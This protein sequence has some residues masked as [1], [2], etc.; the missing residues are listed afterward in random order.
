MTYKA[1]IDS[2]FAKTDKSPEDYRKLAEDAK[3]QTTQAM[4]GTTLAEGAF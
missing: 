3:T 2:I 4:P 1:Y